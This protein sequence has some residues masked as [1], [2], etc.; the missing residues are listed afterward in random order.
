MFPS[1]GPP[2]ADYSFETFSKVSNVNVVINR[3][4]DFQASDLHTHA[5]I[6]IAFIQR[7]HGWHILDQR[8]MRCKAGDVCVINCG[9]AHMFMSENDAPMTIYNLIFRPG[10]FDISLLGRSSF[11]D[12]TSHFLFRTFQNGDFSH[13]LAV[14]FDPA[15][16]GNISRLYAN[17]LG[18]YTRHEP[19]FEE[20]IRAWTTELLVYVFRKAAAGESLGTASPTIKTDALSNVFEYI[21]QN[22]ASAIPLEKLAALTYLSPK[23][24]SKLF[25]TCTGQTVTEYTQRVRISHACNLLENTSRSV[26]AI[27]SQIGYADV[28]F[29]SRLFHRITGMSPSDYRRSAAGVTKDSPRRRKM[30]GPVP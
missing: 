21:Q 26:A 5:F 20:L 3:Y 10:F 22:Y 25:K 29:F 6:E 23:Y 30:A 16:V 28:K 4:E 12:V 9:D 24:F 27:A 13:S 14:H 17:M 18:E 1:I 15:E 2:R 7:G 19:G 11:S 8:I